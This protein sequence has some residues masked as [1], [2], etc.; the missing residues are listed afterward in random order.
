MATEADPGIRRAVQVDSA[1]YAREEVI[2]ASG[3]GGG[4]S[5]GG[6]VAGSYTNRSGTITTGGVSQTLMAANASRKAW[7]VQNRSTGN[8][9]INFTAA[10]SASATG[11][12]IELQPGDAYSE[13]GDFVSTEAITILGATTGQAFTA[14]EA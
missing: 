6:T 9:Y 1:G 4:G 12:S 8:L 2:I 14:K 5:S 10:A 13:A 3:G 7:T 11:G